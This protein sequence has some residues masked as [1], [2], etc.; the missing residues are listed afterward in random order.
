MPHSVDIHCESAFTMPP[1]TARSRSRWRWVAASETAVVVAEMP[2]SEMPSER[3]VMVAVPVEPGEGHAAAGPAALPV[4]AVIIGSRLRKQSTRWSAVFKNVRAS[5]CAD[6]TP[7][8]VRRSSFNHSRRGLRRCAGRGRRLTWFGLCAAARPAATAS[9]RRRSASNRAASP[10]ASSAMRACHASR[11]FGVILMSPSMSISSGFKPSFLRSKYFARLMRSTQQNSCWVSERRRSMSMGLI[12]PNL[13]TMNGGGP[14]ATHVGV[15]RH[16][17]FRVLWPCYG[18]SRSFRRRPFKAATV[19]LLRK[20]SL[21]NA[22]TWPFIVLPHLDF[23]VI[24]PRLDCQR[25]PALATYI[26]NT[27]RAAQFSHDGVTDLA[28]QPVNFQ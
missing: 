25:P 16:Q 8:R 26:F 11:A 21:V 12:S 18:C 17:N 27:L 1:S 19:S 3:P 10:L 20:S 28:R 13:T 14:G 15:R 4:G 5:E 7:C 24:N 23:A 6:A 22:A 9:A 2:A